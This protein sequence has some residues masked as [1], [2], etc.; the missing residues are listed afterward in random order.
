MT[1]KHSGGNAHQAVAPDANWVHCSTHRE[2]LAAKGMPDSF[3][4][5]LDTTVKMVNFVKAMPLNCHVF[6]ALCNCH[7]LVIVFCVFGICLGR[8]GCDMG[9]Y[10]VFRIG[11]CIN[12]DCV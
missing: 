4:D 6:S 7:A 1:G 9:L 3:K 2:A 12:W 8:P 10:V 5:V 11:V